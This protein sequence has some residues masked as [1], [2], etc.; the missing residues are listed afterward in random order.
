MLCAPK[1]VRRKA[2]ELKTQAAIRNAFDPQQ[3]QQQA[4]QHGTIRDAGISGTES[5]LRG[6]IFVVEQKAAVCLQKC[7]VGQRAQQSFRGKIAPQHIAVAAAVQS[8]CRQCSFFL[9]GS[10]RCKGDIILQQ[11]GSGDDLQSP[12]HIAQDVCTRGIADCGAVIKQ[13]VVDALRK[14]IF[15]PS[16]RFAGLAHDGKTAADAE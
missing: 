7:A 16:L 13:Q 4:A 9:C 8:F 15:C 14:R 12:G 5:F 1:I 11:C 6:K 3:G 10:I 2:F